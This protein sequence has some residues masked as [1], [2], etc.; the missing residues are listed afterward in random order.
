MTTLLDIMPVEK[1]T[2]R[3][4]PAAPVSPVVA[5]EPARQAL[6]NAAAYEFVRDGFQTLLTPGPRLEPHLRGVLTD[7]LSHPGSLV[8]AQ[9]AYSVMTAL[10]AGPDAARAWGCAIEYFHTAS[11]LF[12]DLPSMDN[13]TQR[14]GHACPHITHGEGAAILGAL[15]LIN[16]GYRLLWSVLTARPDAARAAATALVSQCLGAEGILNGQAHDL[17][18]DRATHDEDAVLRVASGKTV[19]LTRLTLVLPALICGASPAHVDALEAVA[20]SWGLSYQIMDD[21]KDFLMGPSDTGKTAARD[22]A[23]DRPNLPLTIGCE[24]A[25]QS[26]NTWLTRGRTA[27]EGLTGSVKGLDALLRLQATLEAER[28]NLVA[29]LTPVSGASTAPGLPA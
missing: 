25:L 22:R 10:G 1:G 18:F 5:A 27:I 11:L 8:R 28:R 4:S 14:R 23:L 19:T 15:A 24:A 17:Y 21:F 26:L 2:A 12:D 6:I 16:E 9:L 13:A 29:K 3:K 20:A 7:V